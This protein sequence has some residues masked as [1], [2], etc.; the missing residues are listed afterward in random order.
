MREFII[1][2]AVILVLLALTAVK[3][4]KQI[5]GLIGVARMLK[6]AKDAVRQNSFRGEDARSVQLVN[7]SECGVWV[8]QDKAIKAGN[9][10]ICSE[11]PAETRV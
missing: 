11:H 1:I 10:F 2:L 8:P 3:Y 4:R 6:E 7:C 9:G 5:A